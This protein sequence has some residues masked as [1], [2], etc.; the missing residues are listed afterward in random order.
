MTD[1]RQ[2]LILV[3]RKKKKKMVH[4]LSPGST[5]FFT[6]IIC[7]LALR[8]LR[9]SLVTSLALISPREK[10]IE[11]YARSA[12]SDVVAGKQKVFSSLGTGIVCHFH[13][14]NPRE[15]M[16]FLLQTSIFLNRVCWLWDLHVLSRRVRALK[17][18]VVGPDSD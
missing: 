3:K 1:E 18:H 15:N 17:G 10:S 8:A 4:F 5:T 14:Q 2:M 11:S 16:A 7:S 12:G 9:G 6:S 13:P